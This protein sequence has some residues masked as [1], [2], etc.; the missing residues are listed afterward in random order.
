M[1]E[2]A[3]LLPVLS[4]RA[5]TIC[6]SVYEFSEGGSVVSVCRRLLSAFFPI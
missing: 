6:S 3:Y 1:I 5:Q 2:R 4:A